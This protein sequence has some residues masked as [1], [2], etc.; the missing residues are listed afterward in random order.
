MTGIAK[1][2]CLTLNNYSEEEFNTLETFINN[3][4]SY[5]IIGKEIGKENNTPHLQVYIIVNKKCRMSKLKKVN[6]R[7]HIEM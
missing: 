3:E 1:H 6:N 2:W 7:M 4:C 5:G